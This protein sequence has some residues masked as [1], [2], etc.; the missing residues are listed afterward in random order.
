V[1]RPTFVHG[2]FAAAIF[3]FLASAVAATLAPFLGVGTTVRL[4]IPA[5]GLAYVLYLFTGGTTR[6]GRITALAAWFVLAIVI[7]WWAPP[8]PLY[9][10]IHVAALWVVRSLYY[11]SGIV[12]ALVDLGLCALAVCVAT[13]AIGRTGSVFLTTWCFF[14]V[15]AVFV[16]IPASI[17]GVPRASHDLGID[18]DEF[19]RARRRADDA[20][21]QLL[22]RQSHSRG[23]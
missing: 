23:S 22:T 19:A 21:R 20:L 17:R 11:H 4:V 10:L 1:K 6:V 13:W 9:L 12:P 18:D 8:L 16:A 3:A 7:G 5:L 14:L 15:Q 2:V